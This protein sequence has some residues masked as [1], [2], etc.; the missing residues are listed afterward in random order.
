[1]AGGFL[2]LVSEEDRISIL[3]GSGRL[4]YP[5]GAVI[6]R[7]IDPVAAIVEKGLL[8]VFVQ[9]A[10]GRQAS[11][12]YLHPGGTFAAHEILGPPLANDIQAVT[13]TTVVRLDVAYW[14][15]L[16]E[17]NPDIARA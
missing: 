13:Q 14:G 7:Q 4:T 11:L 10:D 16:V 9:S 3:R 6:H 2:D 15:R 5:A 17:T 8:R 1:M 12:A